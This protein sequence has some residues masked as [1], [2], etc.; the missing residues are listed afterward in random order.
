MET[1]VSLAASIDSDFRQSTAPKQALVVCIPSRTNR[2]GPFL[3]ASYLKYHRSVDQCKFR[4]NP[5]AS[6]IS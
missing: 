3:V 2:F 6:D 5:R 1:R 4:I